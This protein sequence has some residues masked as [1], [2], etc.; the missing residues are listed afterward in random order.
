MVVA[1]LGGRFGYQNRF[2]PQMHWYTGWWWPRWAEGGTPG[3]LVDGG[4][5]EILI[6]LR[7]QVEGHRGFP[8]VFSCATALHFEGMGGE[9]L[10]RKG[11]SKERRPDENPMVLG[12]VMDG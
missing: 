5:I 6:A 7:P 4:D 3:P 8:G 1:A 11:Y 2:D 10:G 9:T 12:V